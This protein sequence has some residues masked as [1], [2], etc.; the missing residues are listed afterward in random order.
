M[1][2]WGGS[3]GRETQNIVQTDF[4]TPEYS[5]LVLVK[6]INFNLTTCPA[7]VGNKQGK[8]SIR[9]YRNNKAIITRILC[10]RK[11]T[12]LKYYYHRLQLLWPR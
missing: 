2:N 7:F 10:F 1:L 8:R 3:I 12:C 11:Y 4:P 6:R 5:F 9:T